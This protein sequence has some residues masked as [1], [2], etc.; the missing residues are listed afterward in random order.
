MW[1]ALDLKTGIHGGFYV[2]KAQLVT[3]GGAFSDVP[4]ARRAYVWL[5]PSDRRSVTQAGYIT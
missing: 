4:L 2:S 5:F 1:S 3:T